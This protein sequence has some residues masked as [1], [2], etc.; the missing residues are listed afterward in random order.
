MTL[1]LNHDNLPSTPT[2]ETGVLHRISQPHG[3]AL[4][5]PFRAGHSGNPAG[6]PKG[7]TYPGDWLRSKLARAPRHVLERVIADQRSP[8]SKVIAARQLLD[9]IDDPNTDA[10][11]RAADRIFDRTEGKAIARQER[12]TATITG[13]AA[14]ARAIATNP[15][16]RNELGRL[17][18][19]AAALVG[20]DSNP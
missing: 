9:A 4:V 6:R 1:K 18:D 17:Y 11:G 2:A 3:G 20:K 15:A 12:L 7:K 5:P 14:I 8:A 10:R 19:R 13:S 16:L